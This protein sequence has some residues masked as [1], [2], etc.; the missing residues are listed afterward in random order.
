MEIKKLIALILSILLV[1]GTILNIIND[2]NFSILALIIWSLILSC[3]NLFASVVIIISLF[4]DLSIKWYTTII[5]ILSA[6]DLIALLLLFI[7]LIAEYF[8]YAKLIN[9]I[10]ISPLIVVIHFIMKEMFPNSDKATPIANQ[11]A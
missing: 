11:P 9:I 3:L 6:S 10:I 5:S 8:D 1:I 4:K 2:L 7:M